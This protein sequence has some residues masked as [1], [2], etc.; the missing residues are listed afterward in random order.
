MKCLA[1]ISAALL[2]GNLG[3]ATVCADEIGDKAKPLEIAEWVKGKKD[4]DVTDG[5][6][7]YVV[8]FWATWCGP[9]RTTIP[10]LT[11][12][13]KEYSDKVVF[14]GVSKEKAEKVKPFVE[15][16]WNKMDYTVALDKEGQ[17][18]LNY[19]KAYDQTG[20]PCAF[21]IDKKG[22]VAWVGHPMAIDEPLK[23]VVEGTYDLKEAIEA[24]KVAEEIDNLKNGYLGSGPE[25]D[26]KFNEL[27]EKIGNHE[28][29]LLKFF[30]MALMY[31]DYDSCEKILDRYAQVSEETAS[32]AKNLRMQLDVNRLMEKYKQAL[33]IQEEAALEK[34]EKQMLEDYKDNGESLLRMSLMLITST[35]GK[36][37]Q[38]SLKLMNEAEAA[39]KKAGQTSFLGHPLNFDANRAVICYLGGD[40][41]NGDLYAEKAVEAEE[42]NRKDFQKRVLNSFRNQAQRKAEASKN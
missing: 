32:R 9:C 29:N 36:T 7:V 17:C 27:L 30:D 41:P 40:I 18:N 37:K 5:K 39:F 35:D 34:L 11:E 42:E 28:E 2:T 8:E 4:V 14:V 19:M 3:L 23:Q 1:Y 13:Q 16:Q 25:K 38:F 21:I 15:E 20:I 24:N 31:E 10:H 12:L 6:S 33:E 26:K 22:R